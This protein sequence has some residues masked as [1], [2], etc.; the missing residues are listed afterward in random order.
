MTPERWVVLGVAPARTTWFTE[1][2]RWS[3]AGVV[4]IEFVK[5]LSVDEVTVRLRSGRSHSALLVD[6]HTPGLSRDLLADAAD[7]GCAPLVV[8]D[9]QQ[10]ADL[11]AATLPDA[12]DR[13][14]LLVALHQHADAVTSV[15]RSSRTDDSPA[16]GG[17]RGRLVGVLGVPG[18]GASLTSM[19]LAHALAADPRHHTTVALA[20]LRLDA[21]QALLHD[22]RDVAPGIQELVEASR[23]GTLGPTEVRAHLFSC[24]DR[25]YDLLLGLRHHHHWTALPAQSVDAALAALARTYR[26]VVADVGSDVEDEKLTGSADLDDRNAMA[27]S[28]VRR[29]DLL[30]VV[31]RAGVQGVHRLGRVLSRLLAAGVP[32]ERL[33]PAIV[34]GPRRRRDRAELAATLAALTVAPPGRDAGCATPVHLHELRQAERAV[35]DGTPLPG[36]LGRSIA[37]PVGAA[38]QRLPRREIHARPAAVATDRIGRWA[39]P[40]REAA[41]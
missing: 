6:A 41:R 11:A 25:S 16:P 27:R 21:D 28:V 8:G 19:A 31:G 39:E 36:A 32:N 7:A 20:D 18:A 13:A 4:P 26:L 15:E 40:V 10:W 17:W 29:A 35:H 37:R 30:V 33:Q 22:A 38:L 5:C 34:C 24:P 3:T 1:L 2:A 14:D 12:F 9:H 23:S